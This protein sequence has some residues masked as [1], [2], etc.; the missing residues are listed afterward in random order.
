MLNYASG[1]GVSFWYNYVGTGSVSIIS[2]ITLNGS[3]GCLR[4]TPGTSCL[5]ATTAYPNNTYTLPTNVNGYSISVWVRCDT[6]APNGTI[7]GL[8][9]I[10]NSGL[11]STSDTYFA[12]AG[13]GNTGTNVYA[14]NTFWNTGYSFTAN[15]WHHLVITVTTSGAVSMYLNSTSVASA[16]ISGPGYTATV[17]Y[18][19][20]SNIKD[21]RIFGSGSK[22]TTTPSYSSLSTDSWNTMSSYNHYMSDFYYF[23]AVLS[24]NQIRWLHSNQTIH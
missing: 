9:P 1:V 5:M 17:T 20:T 6:N 11:G 14:F 3:A 4:S 21:L 23:D 22:L 15:T 2:S 24:L 7:F 8:F 13:P 19:S 16:S 12:F 18:A 10:P